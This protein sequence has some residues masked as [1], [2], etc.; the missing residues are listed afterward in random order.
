MWR[1]WYE[2]CT[3]DFGAGNIAYKTISTD[4]LI[5]EINNE[6]PEYPIACIKRVPTE[7]SE[8]LS[9]RGGIEQ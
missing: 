4:R 8:S 9:G 3:L 5:E 1:V 6:D 2:N 7:K